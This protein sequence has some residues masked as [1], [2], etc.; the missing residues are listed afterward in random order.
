MPAMALFALRQWI[1]EA[2]DM[3]AG[4]PNIGVHQ[5][6]SIDADHVLTIPNHRLPP[7]IFHV[8]LEFD[9]DGAVIVE[10]SDSTVNLA[11]LEDEASSLAEAD[12]GFERDV[13]KRAFHFVGSTFA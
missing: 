9:A 12:D 6:R 10:T 2:V 1:S 7:L 13:V 11:A 8:P 3:T 4:D 5:D